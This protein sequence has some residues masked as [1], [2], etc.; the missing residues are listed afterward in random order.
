MSWRHDRLS[1]LMLLVMT[2]CPS[3]FGREGRV[4]KAIHLDTQERVRK[5]CSDEDLA[6]YCGGDKKDTEE[7]RRACGG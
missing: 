3:E 6:F 4:A 1:I 7:C 5:P 2:G